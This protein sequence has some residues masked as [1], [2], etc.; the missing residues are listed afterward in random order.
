MLW[1]HFV[2]WGM[3]KITINQEHKLHNEICIG[4]FV[5]LNPTHVRDWL[6]F[7]L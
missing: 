3:N 4:A 6:S 1:P 7:P 2:L 5:K